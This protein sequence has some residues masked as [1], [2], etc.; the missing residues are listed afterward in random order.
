MLSIVQHRELNKQAKVC[1]QFEIKSN[2]TFDYRLV[3]NGYDMFSEIFTLELKPLFIDHTYMFH[4]LTP[5]GQ[6][7]YGTS[8]TFSEIYRN[9][10]ATSG[11]GKSNGLTAN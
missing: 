7:L 11:V 3:G 9:L 1:Y 4:Y 5:R 2:D 6:K 8:C 10:N